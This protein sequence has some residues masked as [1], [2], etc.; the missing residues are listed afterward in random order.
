M[1]SAFGV[2]H[3][4][5]SKA[6][7]GFAALGGQLARKTTSFGEGMAA[8]GAAAGQAGKR[9]AQPAG[10]HMGPQS[11]GLRSK[12][13]GLGAGSRPMRAAGQG[14]AAGGAA[15]TRVGGGL[16]RAGAAMGKRPGF[17]GGI[18]AGTAG[19]GVTAGLNSLRNRNRRV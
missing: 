16:Q 7:F 4:E 18:A 8:R 2:E 6:G 15:R 1:I 14:Q 17:T 3:G 5:I 19:A 10:R 9:M 13:P 11:G 12:A